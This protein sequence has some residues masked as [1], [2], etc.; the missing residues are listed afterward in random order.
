MFEKWAKFPILAP[1]NTAK[2]MAWVGESMEL[3]RK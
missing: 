2:P 1:L 3:K